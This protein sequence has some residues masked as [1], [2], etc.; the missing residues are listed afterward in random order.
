MVEGLY[1][2]IA[3]F[4]VGNSDELSSKRK[5]EE[6]IGRYCCA[7]GMEVTLHALYKCKHGVLTK[8]ICLFSTLLPIKIISY[9]L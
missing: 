2:H 3:Y 8:P 9:C 7:R 5:V 1:Y 6:K 4:R